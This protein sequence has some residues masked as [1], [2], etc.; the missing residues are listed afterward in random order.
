MIKAKVDDASTS[1]K[2]KGDITEILAE[3]TFIISGV[4]EGLPHRHKEVFRRL[5]THAVNDDDG[6]VWRIDEYDRD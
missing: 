3:M 6:P 5:L 4:Y 2:V 1:L